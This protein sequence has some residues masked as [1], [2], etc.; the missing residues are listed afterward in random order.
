MRPAYMVMLSPTL[1]QASLQSLLIIECVYRLPIC[2]LEGHVNKNGD[3]YPDDRLFKTNIVDLKAEWQGIM[4]STC[5]LVWF[6]SYR[7]EMVRRMMN[8]SADGS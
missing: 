2:R 8:A 3:I 1:L 4:C 5:V 7:A 6:T